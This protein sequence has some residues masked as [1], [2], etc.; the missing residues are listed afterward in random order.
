MQCRMTAIVRAP[1]GGRAKAALHWS[2]SSAIGA[3]LGSFKSCA[4]A[5]PV[6]SSRTIASVVLIIAFPPSRGARVAEDP[7]LTQFLYR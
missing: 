4:M 6:T 1:D 2:L 3:G 7:A 5:C